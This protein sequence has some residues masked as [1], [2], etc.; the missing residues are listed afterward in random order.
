MRRKRCM[1]A[2]FGFL[3]V[4]V[5]WVFAWPGAWAQT[6]NEATAVADQFLKAVSQG[7]SGRA[8]E[9]CSSGL[10]RGKTAEDFIKSPEIAPIF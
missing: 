9:L 5:F 6:A 1:G 10:R 4:A 2:A 7:D 3:L 8:F